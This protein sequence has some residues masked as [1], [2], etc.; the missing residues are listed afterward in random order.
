[1]SFLGPVLGKVLLFWVRW[2]WGVGVLFPEVGRCYCEFDSCGL[3]N[4]PGMG[5]S[6]RGDVEPD[7]PKGVDW[8]Q[9]TCGLLRSHV[10]WL[11]KAW[12]G[13]G[14]ESVEGWI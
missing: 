12:W 13:G 11:T 1:V 6:V 9:Y 4:V 7:E 8:G 10:L 14:L 3:F 2:C 5:G